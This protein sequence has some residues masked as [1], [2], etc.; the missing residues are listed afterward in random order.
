MSA[1][2]SVYYQYKPLPARYIRLLRV[3]LGSGPSRFDG[4]IKVDLV[5]KRLDEADFDAL[6]YTWGPPTLEEQEAADLQ[7]FTK[8]ERCYPIFFD[9]KI[10]RVTQSLRDVLRKLRMLEDPERAEQLERSIRRK[11]LPHT[12]ADGVCINQDDMKERAQQVGLMADIYTRASLLLAWVGESDDY[13][14]GAIQTALILGKLADITPNDQHSATNMRNPAFFAK[15]GAELIR[16]EQWWE[17]AI[18]LSRPWFQRTWVLQEAMLSSID[19]AVIICGTMTVQ[20]GAILLGLR[21]VY[22]S[23]W[24]LQIS[25]DMDDVVHTKTRFQRHEIEVLSWLLKIHPHHWIS[26][27]WALRK[28]PSFYTTSRWVLPYTMCSNPRDKIYGT[29]GFASDWRNLDEKQLPIDYTLS[30]TEIYCRATK[31]LLKKSRNLDLL[32]I[33]AVRPA[34]KPGYQLPSWC[35][36]YNEMDSRPQTLMNNPGEVESLWSV[37]GKSKFTPNATVAEFSTLNVRGRTCDVIQ[38]EM[39]CH[40]IYMVWSAFSDLLKWLLDIMTTSNPSV[41]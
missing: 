31:Y 6:S 15:V 17:W 38:S 40:D 29:L 4:D 3:H 27:A 33:V 9:G 13:T 8:V 18:L 11:K 41:W 22:G 1:Q 35:P 25:A 21:L 16:P 34:A 30:T 37:S 36:D 32:T 26:R 19:R 2:D 24:E 14:R 28:A 10:I 7:I 39:S 5:E 23:K 12:W 20:M